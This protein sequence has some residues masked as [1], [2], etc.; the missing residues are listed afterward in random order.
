MPTLKYLDVEGET[1]Y[2]SDLLAAAIEDFTYE[3][4]VN[5]SDYTWPHVIFSENK[6]TVRKIKKIRLKK[7]LETKNVNI[8]KNTKELEEVEVI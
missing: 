6:Y 3:N 2:L 5:E 8:L 1:R 4:M 7:I